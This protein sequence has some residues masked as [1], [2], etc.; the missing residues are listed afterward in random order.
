MQNAK[1]EVQQQAKLKEKSAKR[2]AA[3]PYKC[4]NCGEAV[5][6]RIPR[7]LWMKLLGVSKH[8]ECDICYHRCF[9][10]LGWLFK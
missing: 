8:Y 4:P 9:V 5:L 1:Q 2:E 10:F 3:L 6:R 7:K